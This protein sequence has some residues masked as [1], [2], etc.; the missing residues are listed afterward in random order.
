M[1]DKTNDIDMDIASREVF[2]Y[3]GF[4]MLLVLLAL[5]GL[6]VGL[7]FEWIGA[8]TVTDFYG[9]KAIIY[10]YKWYS[11]GTAVIA[12][13][14]LPGFAMLEPRDVYVIQLFGVPKGKLSKQGF[15]WVNPFYSAYKFSTKERNF[16]TSELKINDANG[17]PILIAGIVRW[18]INNPVAM[19]Y[20][21]ED[22]N[23][24]ERF[25]SSQV[26]GN[27]RNVVK[28]HPY[29]TASSEEK[30][31]KAEKVIPTLTSSSDEITKEILEAINTDVEQFGIKVTDVNFNNL[32]YAPEIANAMT[33]KQQ[34]KTLLD[35]KKELTSGVTNLV[36]DT[37]KQLADNDDIK[38][39]DQ[40]KSALA[41]NLTL[42]LCSG[43]EVDPVINID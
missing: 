6:S 36:G 8:V 23:H 11:V 1:T 14:M 25:F 41:K 4:F 13:F 16:E 39:T 17:A 27:F 5:V 32:C 38:L 34:T 42:L 2:S 3:S 7:F 15:R 28:Q 9:G 43:K 19:Y 30:D 31:D 37:I 12:L 26:E 21:L 22:S 10:P 29:D 20:Q 24:P 35:A 40:D 33:A 18:H